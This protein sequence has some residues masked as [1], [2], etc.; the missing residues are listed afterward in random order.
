MLREPTD[1]SALYVQGRA[2]VDIDALGWAR[3]LLNSAADQAGCNPA[4]EPRRRRPATP[5][6]PKP[7]S[8]IAQVAGS[9]TAD[10]TNSD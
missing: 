7:S 5:I 2:M 1:R 6:A 8:I 3:P 4:R 10:V 9:G